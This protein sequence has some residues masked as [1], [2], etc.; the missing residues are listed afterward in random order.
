MQDTGVYARKLPHLDRTVE[1]GIAGGRVLSVSF[2]EEIPDDA[3]GD[4]PLLDRVLATLE[5]ETDDFE[6]VQVALTMPTAQRE[7]LEAT[8]MIPYGDSV[9]VEQLTRIAGL[10]PEDADDRRTVRGALR[11][12]PVPLFVP[13]HRVED[14]DGA[15]PGAIARRLRTLEQ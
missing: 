15:T 9:T 13:D 5:G 2:P 6:D 3:E 8:R 1:I 12:N 14:A 10:D 11:E 4:H 7:V